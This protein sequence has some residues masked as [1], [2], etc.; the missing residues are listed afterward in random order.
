[1]PAGSLS[2]AGLQGQRWRLHYHQIGTSSGTS[3]SAAAEAIQSGLAAPY[4]DRGTMA[5]LNEHVKRCSSTAGYYPYFAL[6][7]SSGSGKTRLLLELAK[8]RHVFFVLCRSVVDGI[9]PSSCIGELLEK[10]SVAKAFL[11]RR[12]YFLRANT[13]AEPAEWSARSPPPLDAAS[14]HVQAA[15]G[16]LLRRSSCQ[17]ALKQT[18]AVS[19]MT[20]RPLCPL[21]SHLTRR[22]PCSRSRARTRPRCLSVCVV[23]H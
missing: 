14:H 1:M 20:A 16:P 4:E 7:Q 23:Q 21:H 2:L 13:S 3:W 11:L 8:R 9:G 17:R 15:F 19:S 22:V 6:I 12:A 5:R 18:L 10:P